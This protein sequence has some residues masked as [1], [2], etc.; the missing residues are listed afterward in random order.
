MIYRRS[1]A[2]TSG[3]LALTARRRRPLLV[4]LLHGLSVVAVRFKKERIAG[5]VVLAEGVRRE[6]AELAATRL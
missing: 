4:V 6:R 3:T 2:L 1:A 5:H